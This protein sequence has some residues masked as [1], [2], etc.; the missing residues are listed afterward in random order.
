M[1]VDLAEIDLEGRAGDADRRT[2]A[3]VFVV[4][5]RRRQRRGGDAAIGKVGAAHGGLLDEHDRNAE[6]GG[7][8]RHRD[9]AR[10]AADDADIGCQFL[11][12]FP[13][14]P[15]IAPVML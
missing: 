6:S 15:A 3:E 1:V 13:V 4:V 9:A 2:A 5:R 10:T 14:Q 11:G 7:A 8:G 12:H